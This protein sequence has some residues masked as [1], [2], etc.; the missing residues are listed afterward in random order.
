MLEKITFIYTAL[1]KRLAE[2]GFT[3]LRLSQQIGLTETMLGRKLINGLPFKSTHI[4]KICDVLEISSSEI[5][6]YFFNVEYDQNKQ[7]ST[8][9]Q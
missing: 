4:Q 2:K 3:Q 9:Q 6:L 8:K 7:N 1:K 5:G